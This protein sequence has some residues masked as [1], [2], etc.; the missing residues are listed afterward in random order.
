MC[1]TLAERIGRDTCC[2]QHPNAWFKVR[3]SVAFPLRYLLMWGCPFPNLPEARTCSPETPPI[4]KLAFG[5]PARRQPM[6]ICSFT[7]EKI[8]KVL[9]EHLAGIS[10]IDLF[11]KHDVSDAFCRWQSRHGK[12]CGVGSRLQR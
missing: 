1:N 6:P 9:K 12:D 5:S 10:A 11:R 8:L 2:S 3:S 4:L 7:E